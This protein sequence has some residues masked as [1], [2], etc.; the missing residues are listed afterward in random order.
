M[1]APRFTLTRSGRPK[2]QPSIEIDRRAALAFLATGAAASLAG[3]SPPRQTA[4]P[5]VHAP[6][7]G[8]AGI[9]RR[10]ATTLT[11]A[12][13]GRGA[14]GICVDGRPIKL[15][16]SALHPASLGSTDVF[17]EAAILD[18]YDPNRQ[19][20]PVGPAGITDWTTLGEVWRGHM[21]DAT[22]DQGAGLV[23]VTGRITSP[24]TL[25]QI[26]RLQAAY[27]KM[28]WSR[29]EAIHDDNA[30]AAG[31]RRSP[32]Y[33]D[34]DV[35]LWIDAD[36]LGAGPMQIANAR[37]I[38]GRRR[39]SG[40]DA[41]RLSR[42]YAAEASLS[43]SGVMADHRLTAD[44]AMQR[45]ILQAVAASL[46]VRGA[47]SSA[48]SP[49]ASRFAA[50]AAADLRASKGRALVEVGRGQPPEVH[51]LAAAVNAALNAPLDTVPDPDTH[52]QSCTASLAALRA[53]LQ[54]HD[55]TTLV[56]L[57]CNLAYIAPDLAPLIG[58]V[59]QTIAFGS[60]LD[61]TSLLVGWRAPLSH[62]LE[63]W[64]D[65]RSPDGTASLSQPLVEPLYATKSPVEALAMLAGDFD[66]DGEA[67]VRQTWP[68]A[69]EDAWWRATLSGGVIS[70]IPLMRG[71]GPR[72]RH[73][74]TSLINT[75]HS[76]PLSPP[77]PTLPPS[78]GE[79]RFIL[80]FIPHPTLWDGRYAD[81]AWLQECPDPITQEVWGSGLRIS[82]ADA[83]RLKLKAGDH[84]RIN[85][86]GASVEAAVLIAETQAPGVFTLPL[87]GGRRV[88]GPIG[89]GVGVDANAL[90]G[91]N[92]DWQVSVDKIERVGGGSKS[93]SMASHTLDANTVIL[94]PTLTVAALSKKAPGP[95][96]PPPSLMP[97]EAQ[98][99]LG[100]GGHAW[101]MAI[102]TAVCI[103][104]NACVTACHAENNVPIVGPEEIAA[105]RDMHWLRIDRYDPGPRAADPQP[106]F[107]PIPCM[108]C[109]HAPCEPVCP[110]EAS[111]HDHDGLND[112]VYNRCV[113]TRFC[114]ANCP[115]QVRR[116]NFRDY[117]SG[118]LYEG[119]DSESLKAQRNPDVTVRGRGVMEKCTYCVQRISAAKSESERTG[120]PIADGSLKTACQSACPTQ[121]ITFGD[122]ND[123]ASRV[124][125]LRREPRHFALLEHL[126]TRPRTT[127]LAKVRNP[128]AALEGKG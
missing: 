108:Q 30:R 93:L 37:A 51:T 109:E 42:L 1:N 38:A 52:P 85:A 72:V 67:L 57:D 74:T 125:T 107:T 31:P 98:V 28:L 127:Y 26:A 114:E 18:L 46:D 111:V 21:A 25:R 70:P 122:L 2:L 3:C 88:C 54:K 73:L 58:K 105:G 59:A 27:P 62:P 102:D 40:A 123:P 36:P 94:A 17:A 68:Q 103:G 35:A 43:Q 34:V 29:V 44:P 110:V 96:A 12:G 19:R 65:A 32:R 86:N 90:R 124:N 7:G 91:P 126:G 47:S 112:Q 50:A 89:R 113:G 71:E 81:N 14:T 15:E 23:L 4:V 49:G 64:S 121:A 82:P 80:A 128:N 6:E 101:A 61:E 53:R 116:F 11:L 84:V 48:L 56:L 77:T 13:Y 104:C 83:G 117:A 100:E 20:T 87:G 66:P 39:P 41:R 120:A 8:A 69:S 97:V 60:G 10:Y 16:G 76:E 115:Y 79:G 24:S 106:V 5:Y 119:L 75:P 78:K 99:Q 33:A 9:R 55:V 118:R 92:L 63:C 95:T 22:K 45:A